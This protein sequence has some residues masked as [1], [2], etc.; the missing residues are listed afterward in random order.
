LFFIPAKESALFDFLANLEEVKLL[1]QNSDIQ[2]FLCLLV[3]L[4]IVALCAR[5]RA[6]LHSNPMLQVNY[7]F[8][9]Q[10]A[11]ASPLTVLD[12]PP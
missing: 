11:P 4:E 2:N 10:L 3:F 9:K 8:F 5:I 12:L 1:F 7:L 6:S